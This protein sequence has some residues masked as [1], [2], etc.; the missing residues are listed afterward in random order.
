MYSA[1]LIH[2]VQVL[3]CTG[4]KPSDIPLYWNTT[5]KYS[6]VLIHNVQVLNSTCY[7]RFQTVYTHTSIEEEIF[8]PKEEEKIKQLASSSS[9]LC[10]MCHMKVLEPSL[11][12][13]NLKLPHKMW[14]KSHH[15]SISVKSGNVKLPVYCFHICYYL[16]FK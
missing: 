1:V 10:V 15:L 5:F 6:K 9:P 3:Q 2:N 13:R 12:G 8:L 14:P 4:T 11:G 16:L 7:S